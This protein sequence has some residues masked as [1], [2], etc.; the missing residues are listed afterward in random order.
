[1]IHAWIIQ[2]HLVA[3]SLVHSLTFYKS[4]AVFILPG[5]LSTITLITL[6]LFHDSFQSFWFRPRPNVIIIIMTAFYYISISNRSILF[7]MYLYSVCDNQ[8]NVSGHVTETQSP[9]QATVAGKTGPGRNLDQ[10]QDHNGGVEIN[11]LS[12][13]VVLCDYLKLNSSFI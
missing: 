6:A 5:E 2:W 4:T 7:K 13:F 9:Q 1:M 12:I 11:E 8:K 10:D 3:Y